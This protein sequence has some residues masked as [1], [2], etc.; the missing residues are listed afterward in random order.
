M[1]RTPLPRRTT[2]LPRSKKPL[3]RTP[4]SRKPGKRRKTVDAAIAAAKDFY[5][6]H[7]GETKYWAKCQ[8]CDHAMSRDFC[9]GHHKIKRS[10]KRDDSK[11]NLVIIHHSC[12]RIV[13]DD[14]KEYQRVRD[15]PANAENEEKI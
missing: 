11:K 5:F 9:A 14:P 13:H 2:P 7:F 1:K 4:I 10:L 15:S 6:K 3:K 8:R 12:H